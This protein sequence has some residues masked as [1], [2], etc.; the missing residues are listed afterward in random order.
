VALGL[1]R[2]VCPIPAFAQGIDPE[3]TS[4]L[5]GI[6][7]ILVSIFNEKTRYHFSDGVIH[8]VA[9]HLKDLGFLEKPYKMLMGKQVDWENMILTDGDLALMRIPRF[10]HINFIVNIKGT[11]FVIENQKPLED[12]STES[13]PEDL[14]NILPSLVLRIG[15]TTVY[16][17]EDYLN[18]FQ[19]FQ[20]N[21]LIFKTNQNIYT[22]NLDLS[23]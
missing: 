5:K 14:R 8:K 17:M 3:N 12:Q 15:D 16:L 18:V 11:V 7:Y 20:I 9:Q 19:W 22:P 4:F 10:N 23:N 6:L 2:P 13:V 21:P 1:K